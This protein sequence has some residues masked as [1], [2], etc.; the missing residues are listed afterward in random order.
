MLL[1]MD[2]SSFSA[3]AT[4]NHS[5]VVTMVELFQSKNESLVGTAPTFKCDQS[6]RKENMESTKWK[7]T[8]ESIV[9]GI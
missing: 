7:Y 9:Y 2:H 4:W 6:K 1:K 5:Y 3:V 8:V